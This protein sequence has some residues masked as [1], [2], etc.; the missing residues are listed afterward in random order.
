MADENEGTAVRYPGCEVELLGVDQNAVAIFRKVRK[1]LI[2]YLVDVEGMSQA[3]ATAKGD[4]F[5]AEATSGDYDH[6]L[7]TC[8]HW[9]TVA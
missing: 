7:A 3:E 2:R 9:V 5:Q 8:H 4:E 6:V 1:V